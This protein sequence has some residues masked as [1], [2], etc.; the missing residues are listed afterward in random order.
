[1]TY[2]NQ[3][4]N[5]S[6]SLS[7]VRRHVL[8][9]F[10]GDNHH[11]Q[12]IRKLIISPSSLGDGTATTP[13]DQCATSTAQHSNVPWK[14]NHRS[15]YFTFHPHKLKE[16]GQNHA[17]H[18]ATPKDRCGPHKKGH[19]AAKSNSIHLDGERVRR[20]AKRSRSSTRVSPQKYRR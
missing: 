19:A 12:V 17:A 10:G 7:A 8:P 5:G 2:H 20:F 15:S 13:W 14:H 11:I 16:P 9:A 1:M 3:P 18:T 6:N 4:I